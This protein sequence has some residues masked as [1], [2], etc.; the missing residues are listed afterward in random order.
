MA[1]DTDRMP[2]PV[3]GKGKHVPLL[4]E[5]ERDAKAKR[6][7]GMAVGGA[8]GAG[9]GMIGGHVVA[10]PA[11]LAAY[12]LGGPAAGLT[13]QLAALGLGG[14]YGGYVGGRTGL[15]M[16]DEQIGARRIGS[17]PEMLPPLEYPFEAPDLREELARSLRNRK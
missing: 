4:T 13:T 6:L 17:H 3:P 9:L 12:G 2:Y 7:A 5:E 8:T 10:S 11:I 16:A 14:A 15:G 1:D